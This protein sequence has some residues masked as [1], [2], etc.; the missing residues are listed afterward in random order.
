MNSLAVVAVFCEAMDTQWRDYLY[1]KQ[2][3]DYAS[4]QV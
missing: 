3:Y 4:L 2:T 1:H